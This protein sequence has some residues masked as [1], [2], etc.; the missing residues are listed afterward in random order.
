MGG[1]VGGGLPYVSVCA[2]YVRMNEREERGEEDYMQVF[3]WLGRWVVRV[4]FWGGRMVYFIGIF[5]L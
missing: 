2:G 5:G 3:H 1:G 4:F